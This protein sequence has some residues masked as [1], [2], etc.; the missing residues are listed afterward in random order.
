MAQVTVYVPD[1]VLDAAR[2]HAKGQGRSLSAWVSGLIR[3]ETATEWPK[4]LVDLLRH[5][6][7]DLVEPDDQPPEEVEPFR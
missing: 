7:G 1:D 3:Q 4:G 6:S 5:G 2:R